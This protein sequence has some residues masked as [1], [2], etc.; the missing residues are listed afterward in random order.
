MRYIVLVNVD[1]V[2]VLGTNGCTTSTNVVALWLNSEVCS[3]T[4]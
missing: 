4:G 3:F 1:G 2:V